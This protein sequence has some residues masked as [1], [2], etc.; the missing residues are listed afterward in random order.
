LVRLAQ[1]QAGCA[2]KDNPRR[3]GQGGAVEI[4]VHSWPEF[5]IL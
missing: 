3:G 5:Y 2:Y 4:R 1:L